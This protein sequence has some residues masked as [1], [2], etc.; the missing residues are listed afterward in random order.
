MSKPM[1]DTTGPDEAPRGPSLLDLPPE[2]L[3]QGVLP[4]LRLKDLLNISLVN[5]ELHSLANDPTLWRSKMQADFSYSAA[6]LGLA[7]P[8]SEEGRNA[9]DASWFKRVYLGLTRP[10]VYLWGE[11]TQSRLTALPDNGMNRYRWN[12]PRPYDVARAFTLPNAAIPGERE[13]IGLVELQ[14]GG[15]SFAARDAAGHVWVWGQLEGMGFARGGWENRRHEVD[16]PARIP[17]PNSC[18]SIA[19]GRSHL[20]VLDSDNLVWEMRAWG[21]AFRHTARSI[22]APTA[23]GAGAPGRA[24]HIAQIAA[25]WEMSALLTAAGEIHVWFPFR[26]D[27]A[28]ATTPEEQMD[29]PVCIDG[30]NSAREF[31]WGTVGGEVMQAADPIPLRPEVSSTLSEEHDA[32]WPRQYGEKARAEAQRVIK[33]ACGRDFIVAL[34]HNGEVWAARTSDGTI[35]AWEYMQHF[36][37]PSIT[38]ISAQF[39]T[40]AAYSTPTGGAV[41]KVLLQ[42]LETVTPACGREL[43]PMDVPGLAD[44]PVVQVTAGDWHWAALTSKGEMYTWGQNGQG[45]LGDG[46]ENAREEPTR[47]QFPPGEDGREAFVFSIAA[48]GMQTG[49]LVLGYKPKKMPQPR[50]ARPPEGLE[51]PRINFPGRGIFGLPFRI[52]YAGRGAMRGGSFSGRG[53]GGVPPGPGGDS[54]A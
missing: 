19:L 14:A 24:P 28:P 36:S 22:T 52:G 48:A 23:T 50:P 32:L 35:G 40:F 53:H 49:A 44:L 3:L 17:L 30:V 34:R 11:A 9:R 8:H 2:V 21:R 13:P 31:K 54:G 20:L 16:K 10:H 46:S 26:N 4:V 43:Q 33:I 51:M 7:A 25:G 39:T 12:V 38:H 45:Q 15:W 47:V 1:P 5:K 29:G 27:Y 42:R 18:T 6:N 41:G 37:L